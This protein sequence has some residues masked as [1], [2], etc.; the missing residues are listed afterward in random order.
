MYEPY[1]LKYYL[2][3]GRKVSLLHNPNENITLVAAPHLSRQ[4][5]GDIP[6]TIKEYV[7]AWAFAGIHITKQVAGLYDKNAWGH[8][9][10][11]D[12]VCELKMFRSR[13]V[14]YGPEEIDGEEQAQWYISLNKP[15]T[16]I[17][18]ALD[19][20]GQPTDEFVSIVCQPL[21]EMGLQG[22]TPLSSYSPTGQ[23]C[24]SFGFYVVGR[25]VIVSNRH[26]RDV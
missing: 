9:D 10:M 1:W 26:Y 12:L 5:H 6:M 3:N 23:M 7:E 16:E 8:V 11:P 2:S 4:R 20:A 25:R 13:T 21:W 19:E 15:M 24:T 22:T 17:E 18:G 14:T